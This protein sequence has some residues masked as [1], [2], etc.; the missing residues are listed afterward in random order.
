MSITP[1][2]TLDDTDKTRTVLAVQQLARGRSNAVGTVSLAAGGTSTVVSFENCSSESHVFLSPKT[3]N[4]AGALATTYVS[5]VG[6]KSFTI[7]HASAA[8][9]DRTFGFVCIG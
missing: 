5:L 7:A 2:P 6:N 9:T 1:L 8:T 3:A 4:A